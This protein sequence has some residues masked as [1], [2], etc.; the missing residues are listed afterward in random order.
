MNLHLMLESLWNEMKT[1]HIQYKNHA[2]MIVD[3]SLIY[4]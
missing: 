4:V 1:K 2:V 3:D